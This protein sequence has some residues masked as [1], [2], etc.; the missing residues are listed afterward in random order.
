MGDKLGVLQHTLG[1]DEYGRGEQ[2]RNH[3]CAGEGHSDIETC[4]QLVA[5]GLMIERQPSELSGGDFIFQATNEGKKWMSAN[6]PKPPALTRGQ[7]RYRGWL[8][9]DS[10]LTFGEYLKSKA[11]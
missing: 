4:R 5:D 8:N 1:V 7:R 11:A 10:G 9:A 6:S 3:F 2:Y